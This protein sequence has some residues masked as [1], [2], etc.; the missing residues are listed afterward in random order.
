[1]KTYDEAIKIQFKDE[2]ATRLMEEIKANKF[3]KELIN[4]WFVSS[5]FM[6]PKDIILVALARGILIG[7]VMER[8]EINENRIKM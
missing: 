1:M 3:T 5:I 6:G 4:M 8:E 2:D 7:M